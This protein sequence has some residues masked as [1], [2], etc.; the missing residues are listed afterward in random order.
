[1]FRLSGRRTAKNAVSVTPVVSVKHARNPFSPE[2]AAQS[3][4][5]PSW[6]SDRVSIPEQLSISLES[7]DPRVVK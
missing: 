2:G 4:P 7:K 6:L 1:M 5:R 3:A